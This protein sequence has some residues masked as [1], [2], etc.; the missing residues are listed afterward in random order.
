MYNGNDTTIKHQTEDVN[1]LF[2]S[3][4][5]L[6]LT[7]LT[8]PLAGKLGKKCGIIDKPNARK[9]H[10]KVIP[11]TG[12]I[13][14]VLATLLSLAFSQGAP[15]FIIAFMASALVLTVFGIWDDKSDISYRIK[16]F[17]QILASLA[18][19]LISGIQ[20]E[21]LGELIPGY[22]LE[23]GV[24]SLPISVIFLLATTNIINLS[25]GLDGLAGGLSL[26]IFLA[27]GLLALP[28]DYQSLLFLVFCVSGALIGFLIYNVH[29]ASIFMGDTGSQFLGFTIGVCL[30]R[31]T[32]NS[33]YSPVL[34]IFLLGTPVIDTLVVMF[35]R[36]MAGASPFKADKNHLHHK[37]LKYGLNHNKSVILLY[38]LHFCIIAFGWSLR[39]ADDYALVLTYLFLISAI[40]N[41]VLLFNKYESLSIFTKRAFDLVFLHIPDSMKASTL[42]HNISRF[43]W[44]MFLT[45]FA[46]LY[47]ISP[48]CIN[49]ISGSMAMVSLAVFAVL[50][51][52]YLHLDDYADI[53]FKSATLLFVGFFVYHME[54]HKVYIPYLGSDIA[55]DSIIIFSVAV[56]YSFCI[57]LTPEKKPLDSLDILLI[58]IAVVISFFPIQYLD[59]QN[60]RYFTIK[61]LILALCI[62]LIF[63]R[64]QRNRKYIYSLTGYAYFFLSFSAFLRG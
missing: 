15:P 51:V 32:Q 31:L 1:F 37:F 61:I 22:S 46:A 8:I 53:I 56:F 50:C 42:R 29:P 14:I 23:L 5:A 11:R 7:T 62:N 34:P 54:F 30:I 44:I 36:V 43:S 35:Q 4:L 6:L 16:F 38:I 26:L 63:S 57:L 3:Y 47:I 19:L 21:S 60:V 18:F 40:I 55:V 41:L 45:S 64:I 20:I 24:F 27:I 33:I 17:G 10:C 48:F 28:E 49:D 2:H 58:S 13:A 39:F 59:I 52:V 25:D 12:G 9:V